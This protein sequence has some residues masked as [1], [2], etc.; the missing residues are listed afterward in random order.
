MRAVLID[1]E[2]PALLQLQRLLA[3]DGRVTVSEGFTSVREGLDY[4]GREKADVVFL[5]I[6]MPEMNGLEAAEYIQQLDSSTRIVYVTA[7]SQYALEAFELYALDYVLKPVMPERLTKTVDRIAMVSQQG[8]QTQTD[9]QTSQFDIQ[10][11]KRLALPEINSLDGKK[12]KLRTAKAQ[13]LLA[14]L[15]NLDGEWISKDRI[16]EA[17]WQGYPLDKAATHL[18]TAVYQ[19]RKLFKDWGANAEVEYAH[20]NYRLKRG[21]MA[22]DVD[23]FE[24]LL[25]QMDKV[26]VPGR[27]EIAK[28]AV[29]LYRGSYLEFH[30]YE[31]AKARRLAL[32]RKYIELVMQL[33]RYELDCGQAGQAVSRL[34]AITEMDPYSDRITRLLI[35]AYG[36][37]EDYAELRTYYEQ[38][39]DMLHE[40]LGAD[41][42]EETGRCY[43]RWIEDEAR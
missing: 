42:E 25:L 33:A 24:E 26:P 20:E 14:Y 10:L 43:D 11:F 40:D 8:S 30:D 29:S 19:I 2:R 16:L 22:T 31:W 5:D 7:Y 32:T 15:L 21:R 13:E 1:D 17:V 12:L 4:L 35:E 28:Q 23:K 18:H 27:W 34:V 3:I 36:R 41:P 9:N 6:G 39:I 38:F 37:L